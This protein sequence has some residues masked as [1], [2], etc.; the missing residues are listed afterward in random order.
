MRSCGCWSAAEPLRLESVDGPRFGKTLCQGQEAGHVA[1]QA[2]E[3]EQRRGGPVGPQGDQG[4]PA[5]CR[6][7]EQTG[8]Q[9]VDQGRLLR[10]GF[11]FAPLCGLDA[12]G[13][14]GDRGRREQGRHR[15][16]RRRGLRGPAPSSARPAANG[17]RVR[18]S[19]RA[20]P[21]RSTCNTSAQIAANCF[22][23]AD[24]GAT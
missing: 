15:Q 10:A 7:L 19:C 22:S 20:T 4:L 23:T 14:F 3:A 6:R 17:R 16:V 2:V 13:Q 9:V 11:D 12:I 1:A 5:A 8:G 18:R 24:R 21:T